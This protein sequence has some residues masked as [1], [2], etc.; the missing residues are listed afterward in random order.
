MQGRGVLEF[1]EQQVINICVEPVGQA[2]GVFSECRHRELLGDVLKLDTTQFVLQ[3]GEF[4]IEHLQHVVDGGGL[5]GQPVG[6][7]GSQHTEGML[8]GG[9]HFGW[10]L[11]FVDCS[12]DDLQSQAP[13]D[14]VLPGH[15]TDI[16]D[17]FLVGPVPGAAFGQCRVLHHGNSLVDL[18]STRPFGPIQPFP[19][20]GTVLVSAGLA[21]C[22]VE[23]GDDI[24]ERVFD[25]AGGIGAGQ[26]VDQSSQHGLVSPVNDTSDR[27][28]FELVCLDV[29]DHSPRHREF[30]FQ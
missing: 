28:A 9:N 17:G 21:E 19:G 2:L 5:I 10:D 4:G 1:V 16:G 24:Q 25:R 13:L 3:T 6:L 20:L 30:K 8:V 7:V 23:V 29:V 12:A 27:F 22:P 11:G 18:G 26:Q 15:G 14:Q